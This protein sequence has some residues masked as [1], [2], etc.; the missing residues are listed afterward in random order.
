MVP[1]PLL[2]LDREKITFYGETRPLADFRQG[3]VAC[4][5]VLAEKSGCS[6]SRAAIIEE[7]NVD[8]EKHNLQYFMNRVRKNILRPLAEAYSRR[9]SCAR[10]RGFDVGFIRGEHRRGG[11]YAGPYKLILDPGRVRVIPPR[12]DWMKPESQP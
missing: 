3:E 2:V 7:G 4:L 12:P 9:H 11:S 6:V 1:E 8:T 5:W 10:P